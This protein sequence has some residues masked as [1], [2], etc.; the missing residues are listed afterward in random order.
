MAEGTHHDPQ[1]LHIFKKDVH[2]C[3]YEIAVS[4]LLLGIYTWR[5]PHEWTETPFTFSLTSA[6]LGW[7]PGLLVL[8][9]IYL[10]VRVIHGETLVGDRQF[11]V[12]RP[13]EWEKLLAAKVLFVA[14]FVNAPLFI[15][16]M[17]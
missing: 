15:A 5:E 14:A 9:W 8:S 17:I 11:W 7:I 12:T 2:R 3:W 6:L 16:Q 13:Y 1:I 10:I 4:L